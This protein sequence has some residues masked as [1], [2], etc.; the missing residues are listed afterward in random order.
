MTIKSK[1]LFA[2]ILVGVLPVLL[3]TGYVSFKI[4]DFLEQSQGAAM[5]RDCEKVRQYFDGSMRRRDRDLRVLKANPILSESLMSDFDYSVVDQLLTDLVAD[6][7]NPF[8][9]IMLTKADGTT[10]GASDARLVGKENANKKWHQETLAKGRYYSD[11]NRRPEKA[12]LSNPPFGGEY[13]YTQVVSRRI[14]GTDGDALGTIN[15][16]VKWQLLQQWLAQEIE[17]F[18]KSGWLS[19]KVT[20][21]KGDGAIIAHAEGSAFYGKPLGE[22]LADKVNLKKV[23]EQDAGFLH[24][25]GHGIAQV[26]SFT[27]LTFGE[28][29]WKILVT[30]AES[31]FFQVKK[32]FLMALAG[33]C[34]F[35]L[36]LAVFFGLLAGNSVA[37][38]LK[39]VVI[40]LQEIASGA[41]DLTVRLPTG[42]AG[43]KIDEI[44]QLSSAFNEFVGKLHNIFKE[45]LDGLHS[46]NAS[47]GHLTGMAEILS[48]G[49][50]TASER[51]DGVAAAAEEMSSNM[52]SVA[53]AVE[54]A[55]TNISQ[56]ADAAGEM[57]SAFGQIAGR[58][59]EARQVTETAVQQ[60]GDATEKVAELGEVAAQIGQVVETITSIS[61][62]TNLLALNA[63]IEA[64][65]AGEAGKGFA[66]VAN[67]IKELAG[68]TAVATDEISDRIDGIQS[69]VGGTVSIIEQISVV[70]NRVNEIVAA[71]AANIE[72]QDVVTGQI[73]DNVGQASSGILEVAENVAQSSTVSGQVTGDITE[74]SRTVTEITDSGGEVK[75]SADE[76]ATLAGRLQE[77]VGNFKL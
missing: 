46:L 62:Q 51:S 40:L 41:G 8:S 22:I 13:R 10:V 74:V 39:Q 64:A 60:V 58:T 38:P 66:V 75:Q 50:R 44:G 76:L 37:R 47:S 45:V 1:L 12:I 19:K 67:E 2:M 48:D 68:Q 31:E 21:V 18:R 34:V 7:D 24:D 33:V 63:T 9:F 57:S 70:I 27:T 17:G 53:A 5:Q 4:S 72:E 54:E 55:S 29:T 49:A 59:G 56:V 65:R 6:K 28:S 25:S 73:A 71:I 3:V 26:C 77:L 35:C 14:S 52:N 32:E 36:V 69:S 16:R 42:A 30:A 20:V 15:A 43:K 11:W 61:A 23:M